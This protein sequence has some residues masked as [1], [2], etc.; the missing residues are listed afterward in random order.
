M[1]EISDVGLRNIA[2]L[3]TIATLT[4]ARTKVTDAGLKELANLPN[5][6]TLYLSDT[7]FRMEGSRSWPNSII[8]RCLMS[9][10]RRCRRRGWLSFRKSGRSVL[11]SG[12]ASECS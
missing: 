3:K 9:A 10:G 7:Q 5:L 8:S 2:K 12:E 11:L 4:L 1:M 6:S